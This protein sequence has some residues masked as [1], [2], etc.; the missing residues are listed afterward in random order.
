[1][2][3]SNTSRPSYTPSVNSNDEEGNIALVKIGELEKYIKDNYE[4]IKP[5]SNSGSG[6]RISAKPGQFKNK[7]GELFDRVYSSYANLWYPDGDSYVMNELGISTSHSPRK[8]RKNTPHSKNVGRTKVS[9]LRIRIPK[10]PV[11]PEKK[12]SM[13]S[14]SR[15][16]RKTR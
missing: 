14:V 3:K 8:S 1:M 10:T 6:L 2:T 4:V 9:N 15:K 16:T 13:C 5:V 11:T 7:Y 12:C